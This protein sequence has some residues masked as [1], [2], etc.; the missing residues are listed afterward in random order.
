MYDGKRK[1]RQGFT[2]IELLAVIVIMTVV[3][4]LL[5]VAAT[6]A[7]KR[8]I[9]DAA[10]AGVQFISSQIDAYVNERGKLPPDTN[11]DGITTEVEIYDTLDEW[12]FAVPA[13]KQV[14]PW[15]NPCIIVLDRD[16]Y[17]NFPLFTGGLIYVTP[18]PPFDRMPDMYEPPLAADEPKTLHVGPPATD[19]PYNNHSGGYQVISAGT[20]GKV[21]RDNTWI[22][23]L[24]GARPNADNFTNWE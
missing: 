24:T 12:G 16:Y 22:N 3:A 2:L 23:P 5:V 4:G 8:S 11:G 19:D 9:N 13:D 10:G 17:E 21:C 15:G 7:R 14:D 20:D 6:G 1:K 18:N